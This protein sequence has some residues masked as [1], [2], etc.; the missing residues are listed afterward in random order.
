M[1]SGVA[2]RIA[3][4]LLKGM[5][6]EISTRNRQKENRCRPYMTVPY[7]PFCTW[8]V[9]HEAAPSM[10]ISNPKH[11]PR[12]LLHAWPH[13]ATHCH[14]VAFPQ[15]AMVSARWTNHFEQI[16]LSSITAWDLAATFLN[17]P[18]DVRPR[19]WKR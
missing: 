2:L 12:D 5:L 1:P 4:R 15:V 16:T 10:K 9:A 6:G 11:P 8:L 3:T 14:R 13:V 18:I 19:S 17:A 7:T